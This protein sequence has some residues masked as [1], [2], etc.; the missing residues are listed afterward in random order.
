M[1]FGI[2]QSMYR[3]EGFGGGGELKCLFFSWIGGVFGFGGVVEDL[4]FG[5]Q[6]P[7]VNRELAGER[8]GIPH[9]AKNERDMGHPL[10]VR[11]RECDRGVLLLRKSWETSRVVFLWQGSWAESLS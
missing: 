9:L 8:S 2:Q 3:W 7:R 1:P 11:K 10:A 6:L 4:G 5:S